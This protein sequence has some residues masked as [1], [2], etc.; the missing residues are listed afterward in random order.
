MEETQTV[1]YVGNW[2]FEIDFLYPSGELPKGGLTLKNIYHHGYRM[3]KDIGIAAI[4]VFP[5]K[6][7][8]EEGFEPKKLVLGT[9]QFRQVD[10]NFA[11]LQGKY[12]PETLY[13][14]KKIDNGLYNFE[15]FKNQI[16]R[17]FRAYW[18][19]T[20]KIFG[21]NS[22]KLRITQK[23]IFTDYSDTPAHEPTGGI[24][25]ARLHP[26]TTVSYPDKNDGYVASIRV[27]YRLH[28]NLDTYA[29]LTRT[30][31]GHGHHSTTINI[32]S[33]VTKDDLNNHVGLFKDLD[34]PSAKGI[35][36]AE[37]AV[38]E[39]AEKPIVAEVIGDGLIRGS[40][41]ASIERI[42]L[43]NTERTEQ[44]TW[45]NIHWWGA[46]GNIHASTPGAFHA[47]HIHWRWAL[48]LQEKDGKFN[49]SRL[50]IPNKGED[51]FVG[52]SK[53]G[54]LTD[55]NIQNQTIKFAIV[56]NESI[57]NIIE[58]HSTENFEDF[59]EDLPNSPQEIDI[60]PEGGADIV[61]YYSSEI[62]SSQFNLNRSSKL[63]GNIFIHGIFFAHELERSFITIGSNEEYY[64]NPDEPNK[65]E[66]KRNPKK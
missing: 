52:H 51:Q 53:G 5:G 39:S 25:A 15:V 45:D 10:K 58:S 6:K 64:V 24:N 2:D 32:Y 54:I 41:I 36:G 43:K 57:D 12:D 66:W 4:W 22:Q 19:T 59:F 16:A 3:A 61:L 48:S 7:A 30:G 37:K 60:K 28:L 27:D 46:G 56:K 63:E 49:P 26:L 13:N 23:Y 62:L 21:A 38:F 29:M 9:E 14:H 65:E 8:I 44:N 50:V 18:E 1:N 42:T 35:A 34:E 47:L 33:R 40:N 11:P 17:D 20:E 31:A 55:P